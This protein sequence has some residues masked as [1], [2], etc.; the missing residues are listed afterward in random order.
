MSTDDHAET[1]HPLSIDVPDD[2]HSEK[3]WGYFFRYGWWFA[4]GAVFLVLTNLAKF[5]IPAYIGMAVEKMRAAMQSGQLDFSMVRSEVIWFGQIIMILA[6]A[7]GIARILSRITIFYPGR[8]I[9]FDLRNDLYEKLSDLTPSFYDPAPTG[10]LTSRV[11][12]DVQRVRV[13]YALTFLHIVN[14]GLAYGIGIWRMAG[15]D[16]SLTLICLAPYPFLL[17]GI[18]YLGRA[19]F[20]Q[21]KVVQAKLS[22]L[23]TKV[24]ENLTGM[25]VVK[26]F[27]LEGRESDQYSELN[28][29][30]YDENMELAV[31]RGGLNAL[32]ALV[33]GIGTTMLL[34][35]GTQRVLAGTLTLGQ[36]VEFNGYVVALAFPTI[37]M[38]WVFQIWHRGRAAFDRI[39]EILAREPTLEDPADSDDSD[40]VSLPPVDGSQPRGRVDMENVS[41]SYDEDDVLHDIDLTIPA[42]STVAFVGRTG[43]GK[44]TLVKLL[45]RLY[46]P[47]EG[48]IRLDGAP[49]DRV[50][51]RELRS[52]IGFVPQE[53]LLFSMTLR[54]N[55]RFGLDAF[56]YDETIGRRAPNSAL[57]PPS[58]SG[59]EPPL[60]ED[61]RVQQAIDVAGLRP[62]ID[63]FSDGLETLVGERGVTLSGGQKQRVT[64]ARA[65]LVDPRLLILDDAL[66]SVDTKTEHLILDR[67]EYIMEGRTSILLTHRFN[68]LNRVD[69]IY[70]LEQG[71]I[72]ERGTHDEL[73]EQGGLY[74]NMYERQQLEETLES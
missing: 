1:S 7:A 62:D 31:I 74:A 32:V 12:N 3:L 38:G 54:Q 5:A 63:G 28:N 13:F 25:S 14:T 51:L 56:D 2:V 34:I 58:E 22:D 52:E 50:G 39:I 6:V 20:K 69:R 55:I 71:E 37:A 57:I 29:E 59:L 40:A 35:I 15:V 9:E 23:S 33:A 67:L 21:T 68:A 61:Q 8:Y 47:D 11:T 19:L 44:S 4:L 73:I 48:T 27:V 53:P 26:S 41:F 65:L 16:L 42:G 24:Q 36:F 66:S 17:G 10:D 43:S 45:T 64:L 46:D 49:I 18:L 72:I 30:F 70:V 60:S